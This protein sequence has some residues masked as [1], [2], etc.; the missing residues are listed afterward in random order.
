MAWYTLDIRKDGGSWLVTSPDFEELVTFGDTKQEA[1]TRAL[2][3]IEEAIAGRIADGEDIPAPQ[4]EEPEGFR[5]EL[6]L[7]VVL[8]A[9]LYMLM[10]GG[11]KTRADLVRDLGWHR[12]QVDRLF[13]L[14]H[15]S[16]IDQLEEAYK[17]LGHPLRFNMPTGELEAA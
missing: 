15:N 3:A 10:R 9:G 4:L 13:R 17:A 11:N 7:L 8:K 16:R 14:D 2:D 5:V 12:E 6:S 1:E